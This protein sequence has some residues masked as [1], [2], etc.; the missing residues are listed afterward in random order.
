MLQHRLGH[1]LG[2]RE[3]S[4]AFVHHAARRF[5]AGQPDAASL[6]MLAKAEVADTVVGTVNEAMTLMGGIAYA[7]NSAMQR[8]LRDARAAHVMAPTTD[9]LRIWV[10]RTALGEPLLAE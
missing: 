4:R 10:G 6:V 3:R 8:L 9:L 7:E 2:R 1:L 5:D